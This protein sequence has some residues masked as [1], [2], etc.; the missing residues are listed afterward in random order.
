MEIGLILKNLVIVSAILGVVWASQQPW[1]ASNAKTYVYAE[2]AKSPISTYLKDAN[3]WLQNNVYSKV[4]GLVG[5]GE[6]KTNIV[7]STVSAANTEL[8]NQKNNFLQNASDVSREFI[9]KEVLAALHV[10][11][12]DLGASCPAK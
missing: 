10:T 7:N 6:A 1:G 3:S 5:G 2:N 4:G 12:Q 11:P 8:Q 9:A